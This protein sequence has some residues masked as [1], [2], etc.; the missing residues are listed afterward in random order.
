M[1]SD[2]AVV[3]KKIKKGG[4]GGHHGGAWK[5]AYAD[6]VTAM[7]AF[8]LLMWLIN[9]T[10][11]EQKRGIA[12]YFSAQSISQTTSGAGG[13]LGGT[14]SG[15]AGSQ[16]GG[17]IAITPKNSP[18]Q[19]AQKTSTNTTDNRKGGS[20]DAQG[21]SPASQVQS[22]QHLEQALPSSRNEDFA[23]AA[24]SIR[25][26]MQDMPDIAALS[27]QVIVEQTQDGLRIQLV[28]QDQRPMFAPGTAQP[29][30]YT[31][32]MLDAVAKI[33][34][35]L[36]NRI[37]ISGH[38]DGQAFHGADG[39]TN[40]ELSAARANAARAIL[41][42]SGV[43]PDRIYEVAGKAGSE[44]L[45]PEDPNASANRRITILLMKEA[46]PVPQDIKP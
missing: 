37:S 14:I 32:K 19:T 20:T 16:A 11:P 31:R 15:K 42:A 44:P 45:L 6:F 8:F 35:R 25:Q 41:N 2:G 22:D 21:D 46:P 1:A 40:W 38:T 12:D 29:M 7:M 24:E 9:T 3:I 4:H 26:A 13:V 5:V 10:T 17:S 33:I 39:T 43:N 34:D 36:P 23:T 28:D 27:R 18:P 30:P